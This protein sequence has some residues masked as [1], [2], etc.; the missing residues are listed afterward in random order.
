[1]KDISVFINDLKETK[2]SNTTQSIIDLLNKEINDAKEKIKQLDIIIDCKQTA[3]TKFKSSIFFYMDCLTVNFTAEQF[4]KI[5]SDRIHKALINNY[6]DY[7][8]TLGKG[9][10]FFYSTS[11]FGENNVEKSKMIMIN[12][13]TSE[14]ITNLL[15]NDTRLN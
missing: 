2:M 12:K 13:D 8:L 15:I 1:M 7:C 4:Q 3:I 14:E 5:G 11:F 10:S 6:I 9:Y